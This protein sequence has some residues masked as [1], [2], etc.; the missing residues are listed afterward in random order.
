MIVQGELKSKEKLKDLLFLS[1]RWDKMGFSSALKKKKTLGFH[2]ALPS[3]YT[4]V[5]QPNA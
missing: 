5:A 1:I 2:C 3:P 4:N